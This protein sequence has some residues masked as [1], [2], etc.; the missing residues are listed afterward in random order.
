MS[1]P[2]PCEFVEIMVNRRW[3]LKLPRWRAERPG[4]DW[5]EEEA[6]A[7]LHA[8]IRPRDAVWDVGAELGD[9][10]ALYA[11]WGAF[12]L[13]IEPGITMWPWI[14]QIARANSRPS[15]YG[16]GVAVGALVND[17]AWPMWSS[18]VSSP[19]RPYVEWDNGDGSVTTLDTI[20]RALQSTSLM[21]RKPDVVIM[22]IEGSE[23]QALIGADVLVKEV[24]P[25]WMISVHP[26]HMRA[27]HGDT[28]DDALC[29]MEN[30]GYD[31]HKISYDHEVHYLMKPKPRTR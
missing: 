29:H 14:H 15:R 9:L 11:T 30:N 8:I 19:A 24:R 1:E 10:S 18:L 12:V 16:V 13:P 3:P 25:I 4:W 22:D 26:E 27:R 31:I 7:T 28:P 20:L 21:A 17:R 2:D 23:Y 6:L 5:W